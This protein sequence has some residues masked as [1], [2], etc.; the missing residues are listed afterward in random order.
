MYIYIHTDYIYMYVYTHCVYMC[1][2]VCVYT[3]INL[4]EGLK[5]AQHCELTILQKN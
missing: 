1:V 3:L 4:A 2:C 5:L